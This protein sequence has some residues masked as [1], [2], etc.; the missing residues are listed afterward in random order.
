MLD[1]KLGKNGLAWYL[2]GLAHGHLGDRSAGEELAEASTLLA[3]SEF[4]ELRML[5][6]R[7]RAARV[8]YGARSEASRLAAT[9]RTEGALD[10]VVHLHLGRYFEAAGR[11]SDATQHFARAGQL[12][13]QNG[14]VLFELGSVY[15][16]PKTEWA[17]DLW[18]RYLE[19]APSGERALQTKKRLEE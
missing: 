17:Y 5:S 15:F 9:L 12:A 11:R 4:P 13:E 10:P 6:E 14:R 16:G 19:L 18:R 7:A 1:G 2:S 8:E 3:A